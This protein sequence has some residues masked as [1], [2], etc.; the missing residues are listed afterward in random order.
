M[1]EPAFFLYILHAFYFF[2]LLCCWARCLVKYLSH[3]ILCCYVRIHKSGWTA[4]ERVL[5]RLTGRARCYGV[6][7]FQWSLMRNSK[8]GCAKEK[9]QGRLSSTKTTSFHSPIPWGLEPTEWGTDEPIYVGSAHDRYISQWAPTPT[10]VCHTKD[11]R[12]LDMNL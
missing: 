8:K 9:T 5:F 12:S 11:L 7:V 6:L 3:F 4:K 10:A 2:F 1:W